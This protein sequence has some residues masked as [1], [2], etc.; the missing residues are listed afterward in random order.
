MQYTSFRENKDIPVPTNN[1]SL[2]IANLCSTIPRIKY[3]NISN[4]KKPL[5]DNGLYLL[6][7]MVLKNYCEN[8]RQWTNVKIKNLEEHKTSPDRRALAHH[9]I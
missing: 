7:S 5:A 6:C 2:N 9:T 4:F 1:Y 3:L 8:T